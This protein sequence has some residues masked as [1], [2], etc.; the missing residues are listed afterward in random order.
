MK[1][2]LIIQ[3]RPFWI[4]T[5]SYISAMFF[6][7]LLQRGLFMDGLCYSSIARNMSIG[8][9]SFWKPHFT[10]S[11]WLPYNTGNVFYEHL[12]LQFGIQSLFFDL[13]GDYW[14]VEKIYSFITL[15]ITLWIIM[16]I[17]KVV[18]NSQL[19]S[20]RAWLPIL[21]FYLFPEIIWASPNNMLENTMTVFILV[22]VYFYVKALFLNNYKMLYIVMVGIAISLSFLTKGPVGLFPLAIPIIHYLVFRKYSFIRTVQYTILPIIVFVISFFILM[23][24]HSANEFIR[25]FMDQQL[26]SS[27]SGARE[28][29]DDTL[30]HF[31]IFKWLFIDLLPLSGVTIII[32]LISVFIKR[33]ISVDTANIKITIFFLLIALAGSVLIAIS[34]KQ[35]AIYYIPSLPY[36]AIAFA[37]FIV[38]TTNY[39][40]TIA[41]LSIKKTKILNSLLYILFVIIVIY[42]ASITGQPG[43]EHKLHHD[44]ELIS[45]LI[46]S[47]SKVGVCPPM[48][49]DS[50]LIGYLQRYYRIA[51]TTNTQETEFFI[52]N[53]RCSSSFRSTLINDGFI[54]QN[55]TT[56]DDYMV[57]RK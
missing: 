56:L 42:T 34:P 54:L 4:F 24:N 27:L 10:S 29:A 38:P 47:N 44:L 23:L 50:Y 49:V 3:N 19:T 52:L 21:M 48:M 46:P 14:Y 7:R 8:I 53:I 18:F 37:A 17:W 55:I 36:Y 5:I 15:F 31:Y 20:S 40:F 57:Y 33:S 26:L 2:N 41:K 12:P 32:L 9:G 28:Q 6:P 51:L 35:M 13:F 45:D 43:R 30:G 16:K 1:K 39:F 22:A 25:T 11:F